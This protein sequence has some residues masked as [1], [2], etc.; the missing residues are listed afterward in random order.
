M[1]HLCP[2]CPAYVC[3][4]ER[5]LFLPSSLLALH[6][7]HSV[8]TLKGWDFFMSLLSC[9]TY[10]LP[11]LKSEC[12]E[13]SKCRCILPVCWGCN[14]DSG[15]MGCSSMKLLGCGAALESLSSSQQPAVQCSWW[16]C[17]SR[18]GI[19][20]VLGLRHFGHWLGS[21]AVRMSLSASPLWIAFTELG[22]LAPSITIRLLA[23]KNL[24]Q[25]V[26]SVAGGCMRVVTSRDHAA[27]QV[28]RREIRDFSR[29]GHQNWGCGN[30]W[31]RSLD[32]PAD[33]PQHWGSDHNHCSWSVDIQELQ[34]WVWEERKNNK[35]T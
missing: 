2:K 10:L 1:L 21:L 34:C 9:H 12:K 4:L 28:L 25:V 29:G 3:L 13:S 22:S 23:G 24:M 20:T 7:R 17:S 31:A 8:L 35:E 5:A 26:V 30:A 15:N 33:L 27:W 32:G 6:L 19:L 18:A 11:P 16:A 14:P